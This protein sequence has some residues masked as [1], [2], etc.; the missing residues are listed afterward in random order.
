MGYRSRLL[1][2]EHGD[3]GAGT[4]RPHVVGHAVGVR[5]SGDHDP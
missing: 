3:P 2:D 4:H 5:L 1:R